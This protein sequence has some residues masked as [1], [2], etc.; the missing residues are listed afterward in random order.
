MLREGDVFAGVC[1]SFCSRGGGVHGWSQ[2]P[3]GGVRPRSLLGG[4]MPGP[5]SHLGVGY[6]R[7]VGYTREGGY[8]RGVGIQG[9]GIPGGCKWVYQGLGIHRIWVRLASGRYESYWNAFLSSTRYYLCTYN[10]QFKDS[11][12]GAVLFIQVPDVWLRAVCSQ[13]PQLPESAQIFNISE[14]ESQLLLV[15]SN[16]KLPTLWSKVSIKCFL[17]SNEP[18]HR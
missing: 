12:R 18:V 14:K 15:A 16:N 11:Q 6:T 2:V 10:E 5:R 9:L 13:R 1:Q 7:S 8:T 3:S 4:S 17:K